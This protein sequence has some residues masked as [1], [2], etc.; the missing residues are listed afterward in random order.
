L[1]VGTLYVVATPIGNLEDFSPRGVRVLAEVD[2][3][4]AEDTRH[5]AKLLQ[6][7]GVQTKVVS[8]HDYNE[9]AKTPQLLEMLRAG[10]SIALVS[11][12]GTPLLSDPGFHLVRAARAANVTIV[13]IPGPCA[14]IA[15]LSV[16]G[17]PTDRFAFEGFPPPRAAARRAALATLRTEPR[18]MVFYE[19]SHRIVESLSDMADVFGADRPAAL[20]R[21]ITKRFETIRDGTLTDLHTY[22]VENENER[23]GEFVVL[24]AGAREGAGDD[25]I[26]ESDRVLGLLL[27]EVPLK[28]A[29][30]LAARLTGGHKN[31]LYD[32]ALS[33]KAASSK[34]S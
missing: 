33:I 3:I 34:K 18:T 21:E 19:S 4:A 15:A 12:A 28:E 29:V 11:D 13:P 9:R 14:A 26:T 23:L 2:L 6:H 7:Y 5:S 31:E 27:E 30:K 8:I 25:A 1:P 20:A 16:A 22:L 32:R 24:I 10:K 17:L